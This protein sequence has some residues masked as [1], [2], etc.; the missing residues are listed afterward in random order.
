[1][2]TRSRTTLA[3]LVLGAA[4]AGGAAWATIPDAG[5]VYTACKLNLTGTIR[6]IDPSLPSSSFHSK[7]SS[8]ETQITW[9]QKG[10][11][12][13][14]GATGP[15]GPPGLKG[16]VGPVGAAGPQGPKGETGPVGAD[17][18]QGPKGDPGASGPAGQQGP[19]G[20]QGPQGPA[21]GLN[22]WEIVTSAQV[23]VGGL[24]NSFTDAICSAGKRPL[25]GGVKTI[26]SM[27]VTGSYPAP[28]GIA[29]RGEVFNSSVTLGTYVVYA[30]CA[31]P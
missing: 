18:P 2:R 12:G 4:L 6:L 1:M 13:P 23:N 21:G 15:A 22:G 5:G 3:G 25:G 19:K 11:T 26:T 10:Q 27:P 9:N 28:N 16:E 29:W 7:C 17:G 8:L 24:F 30:V 14:V 31:T 20:D